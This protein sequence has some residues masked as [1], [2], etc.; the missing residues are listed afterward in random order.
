MSLELWL[1]FIATYSLI[2]IVPGPSVLM[3]VSQALNNGRRAAL[4]CVAGDIVGGF[5]IIALALLGVGTLLATSALLFQIV[6]WCGVFYLAYLGIQQ[7][8]AARQLAPMD[9]Q[10]QASQQ[11]LFESLRA[12]FFV[13]VLNPK[14]I[15][16][17]VSFLAQFL[18][19]NGNTTT[20][21]FILIATSTVI[22]GVVLGGYALLAVQAQ[23][24]FQS[25]KARRR[26][27]YASGTA[28]L[29]GSIWVSATR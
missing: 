2:S 7:I 1:A 6:K 9:V 29:G 8:C 15:M 20:Q 19:P 4:Y 24:F 18:D 26:L 10:P 17:Y 14:A 25:I 5:V 27:G 22:V 21:F 12:G 16:F 11:S 28:M 23:R 13:G 3:V